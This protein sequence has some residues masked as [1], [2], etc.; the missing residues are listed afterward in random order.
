MLELQVAMNLKTKLTNNI[1][2]LYFNCFVESPTTAGHISPTL[3]P[4]LVPVTPTNNI[5]GKLKLFYTWVL[6]VLVI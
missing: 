4:T 1:L 5:P 3:S 2:K 6:S